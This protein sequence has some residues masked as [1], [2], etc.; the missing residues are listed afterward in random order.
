MVP[1]QGGPSPD[2]FNPLTFPAVREW[3]ADWARRNRCGLALVE[4]AITKDVT[5]SE[6]THCANDA[7]VVLYT[8]E[9]G[10]HSWPGGK[11]MPEWI[12]GPTS[13][14]VDATER[15]W[16]FFREHPLRAK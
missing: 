13:K 4:S 16:A 14:S 9:G 15:M 11:P 8:I 10:G 7:A 3:A 5:R 6:Y 12:V 2:P 1:Y